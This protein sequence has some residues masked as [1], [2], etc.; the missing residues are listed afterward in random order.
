MCAD[1]TR[2]V[3]TQ[4]HPRSS[5]RLL[6]ILAAACASPVS[7]ADAGTSTFYASADAHVASDTPTTNFGTGTRMPTD[8]DP[9]AHVMLRFVVSGLSG[10]V[11]SARLRLFANNPTVDG[12][13]L[14]RTTA[15]WT[16]SGVTWTNRPALSGTA[17]G[18]L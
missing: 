3:M 16:E 4:R 15:A 2:A 9:Q 17:L 10:S 7:T 8:G 14:Y 5:L 18:D 6:V 13:S 1:D 12:P 11:T